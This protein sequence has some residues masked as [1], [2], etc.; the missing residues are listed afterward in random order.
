MRRL[1]LGMSGLVCVTTALAGPMST[2]AEP[3]NASRVDQAP[4]ADGSAARANARAV[5]SL[6]VTKIVGGLSLPWDAKYTREGRLLITER[7]TK[8]LYT[9][10]LGKLRR[11]TFP[12][13]SVYAAGETGL[14]SL[15]V[16]P[17]YNASS[18][19]RFY[20]CQGSPTAGGGHDV[21][22]IA[23]RLNTAATKA[24]RTQTVLAGL[25]S[26][27]GRHG[28]CRMLIA[29]S[30]AMM[31]GTG[32][33]ATGTNPQDLTSLGGKT[34]R[35]NRKTGAPWPANPF[36]S[37]GNARTR[38][39]FTYGHRNVQGL[40][41]RADGTV[42]SAEHGSSRDDEINQLGAGLNYGWNPVPGYDESTPM[43]DHDLPGTQQSA[44][45][46]SGSPTVATSGAVWVRGKKWG[47]YQNTLAVASLK[48][49]RVQFM[50]FNS[51]GTF[52]GMRTPAALRKYGRLRSI[53]RLPNDN[54]MVTTSN[55][56]GGKRVD[57]V[58]RVEPV[59]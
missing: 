54:L 19:R 11:V 31:V 46:S 49:E 6:K 35:L 9:W 7:A 26:V 45:W 32:D 10:R 33:A 18:N 23:W 30:G 14:M 3:S 52:T 15:L 28:G 50:S 34:L 47:A 57:S 51:A 48:G 24:T 38:Y 25:P 43:T 1:V 59:G 37:S 53:T 41:L 58:L 27:T 21:R 40:A 17:G 56:T 12:A 2:A 5:P 36:I 22:V 29:R 44:K 42:W 4:S 39:V 55:S 8:R 20:T 16:E 13:S